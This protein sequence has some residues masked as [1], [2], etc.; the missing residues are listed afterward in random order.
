MDDFDVEAIERATVAA[1]APSEVQE[2]PGW[3]I[4]YDKVT[5]NRAR[6]AV[7][8]THERPDPSA[9]PC[10]HDRYL[11]RGIPPNFRVAQL[12]SMAPV[13][14][15]LQRLPLMPQ[16][17]TQVMVADAR[18]VA[19]EV[20]RTAQRARVSIDE[21]PDGA[22]AGLF[23]G[24]GFDPA[25]GAS[26]VATLTRARGSLFAG[27][28]EGDVVIA[29]GV[30]AMSHGWASVHGMRTALARRGRGLATGVLAALA[31]AAIERG[32]MRLALQVEEANK[33]ARD[34]YARCGFR[35]AWTYDYWRHAAE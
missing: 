15:E 35:T 5:V 29:G 3:L 32:Y 12:S 22:W 11:A 30:L 10:I 4:A 2:L 27:V 25:D 19:R 24:E 6:S 7:P 28:R 26:R 34:V 31:R 1:V 18:D 23:V 33:G 8:L 13:E 9:V 16:Q 20:A 14:R 21:A 17:P